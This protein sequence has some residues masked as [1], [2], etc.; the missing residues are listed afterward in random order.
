M[1]FSTNL[2]YG[3]KAIAAHLAS[4]EKLKMNVS[5]EADKAFIKELRRTDPKRYERLFKHMFA[6]AQSVQV[7]TQA[8]KCKHC[9]LVK[10]ED[11]RSDSVY[12]DTACKK[13]AYR[14]RKAA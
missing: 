13:A 1:Q 5:T 12:C 10:P 4:G 6:Q 8:G 7:P 3:S 11:S 9:G 2:P 14:A